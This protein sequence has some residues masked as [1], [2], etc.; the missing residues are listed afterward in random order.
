[1]GLDVCA[2][3]GLEKELAEKGERANDA[4]AVSL[5]ASTHSLT[6][7]DACRAARLESARSCCLTASKCSIT[8]GAGTPG[9]QPREGT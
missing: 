4:A 3:R 8:I 5:F 9:H 7:S 6:P 2:Q 1:M